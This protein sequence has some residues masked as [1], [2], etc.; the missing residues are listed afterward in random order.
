MSITLTASRHNGRPCGVVQ[1][2][3]PAPLRFE[4]R[5]GRRFVEEIPIGRDRRPCPWYFL[6]NGEY[7]VVVN[8]GSSSQP[9]SNS[10]VIDFLEEGDDDG[11]VEF[12]DPTP[13][14]TPPPTWWQRH[15]ASVVTIVVGAALIAGVI[16][17]SLLM[18]KRG[19]G[20]SAQP[21]ASSATHP[22]EAPAIVEET[23]SSMPDP[24]PPAAEATG[25]LAPTIESITD[26]ADV[27]TTTEVAARVRDGR[28]VID[29]TPEVRDFFLKEYG[30]RLPKVTFEGHVG[31]TY[32]EKGGGVYLYIPGAIEFRR[33]TRR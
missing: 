10:I 17:T 6:A 16:L 25:T 23:A 8:D 29:D 4:L 15:R 12:Y 2:T 13:I 32:V 33:C 21:V 19:G 9:V 31:Y 14:P 20:E 11:C 30:V 26:P 5:R 7:S 27:L 24:A 28:G 18:Q 1:Y 3:G 22:A